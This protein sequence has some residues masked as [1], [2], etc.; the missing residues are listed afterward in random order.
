MSGVAEVSAKYLAE[1]ASNPIPIGYKQTD[2][3]LIP[4]DWKCV[5]LGEIGD[6][7]RGGSPRPAGDSRFFNGDFIPWLTVA[8]LTNIPA[9]EIYVTETISKLTELG[10]LQS[11]T[12]EKGT[13]IISNSGATLGV[14]KIL[15]IKCCANDGVAAIINQKMGVREFLVY[16]FNT[17]TK[18]LHDQVAT[19]NG[20]PNLNTDLI[21][22]IAVPFPNEKEQTAI[23][24]ALSDVDAIVSELEELIAKKQAIKTATMQQLL[25]GRTR[26]PQFALREDGKPKGTKPSELGE[27]PED[28][29][30]ISIGRDTVL[31]ARIG[32]Q[33]LT[34]KEYQTTGDIYLVTGTD[35]DSGAV[36][37]ERCFYVS[38]W[39]YKQ[40]QNIQLRNDDVLI[41]KDGT[42]GKVGYVTALSRP[43]TLNSG[44][45]VVRPKNNN[46]MQRFLFYVLTSR[47]FD[48]FI[49]R[50]TAG[51]TITHLYQKDFV[52]FEFSAPCIEE[53]TAIA[54]ILSDM[55]EEI[56]A[57]EQRLGKTRQIK[58]GMMQELLTGKTRLL[59]PLNKE[60]QH[61]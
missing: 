5:T 58:Q 57:L 50:I 6:I 53:Q 20:Q 54:T 28:W 25:T 38:E 46:L 47:V 12:L 30:R 52:N 31:K 51:S 37:W 59:Q 17:Q 13:L 44:V 40:D 7:V 27:I 60:S 24:N 36:K 49:N 10:S 21:K 19:G 26:L 33:A 16:Y 35:F 1:A 34:T 22:N 2:V 18:K 41:T 61:G 32:W 4:E 3:G 23:A 9:S 39:R 15:G 56:Q 42:I 11:R 43:A 55:D 14:A 48:D 8:S 29:E 45:F